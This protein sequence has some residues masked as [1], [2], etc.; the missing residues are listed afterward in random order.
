MENNQEQAIFTEV[1]ELRGCKTFRE[2]EQW[3]DDRIFYADGCYEPIIEAM[4]NETHVD[5]EC[6]LFDGWYVAML[7]YYF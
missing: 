3:F 6:Y 4:E 7:P 2:L 1:N 5:V